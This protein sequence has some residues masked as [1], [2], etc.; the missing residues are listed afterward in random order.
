MNKNNET[1][2]AISTGSS[3]G[4][5]SIVRMSGEMST[6]I[7]DKIFKAYSGQTPSEFEPRYLNL[8]NITTENFS[9]QAMCVVFKA[10]KSYTGENLVEFQC[11]GGTQIANGIM[12]ECIKHGAR[13]ATNGEFTKRAFL[14]GK[15]S[16][17]SAEGMMDMIN[18]ESDAEIRAGY[19]LLTGN[20]SK[21]A[22]S[23]Q[24][25]LTDILSE[26]EVSF[27]YPEEIIEYIT[28]A[29]V[30]ERLENLSKQ[31]EETIETSETGKMIKSGINVLIVGRPNV[32]KSSLLNNLLQKEK[33][34]VTDIAGTTRDTVEG[35][36]LLDDIKINLIDTA[37]IHETQDTVEKIGVDKAKNLISQA[38]IVLFLVDSNREYSA[39]DE[40]IYNSIK[41]TKYIILRTKS[42]LAENNQKHF[43]DEIEISIKNN[44]GIDKLKEKILKLTKISNLSSGS[45]I[46]TNERHKN[47][48]IRSNEAI[49]RA[50]ENIELDSLDLIAIDIKQ[51]YIDIGEITGNTTSEEIIDSIF[52]K[53][54]LG[55]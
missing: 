54:C 50:I 5:I 44:Q 22:Y 34:I 11:H 48:L 52:S 36:F 25:E 37:G 38:D 19:E 27:D 26:I 41:N 40:E 3:S 6:I 2:V 39:D 33:A 45:V 29:K 13:I 10:P 47:A 55:K 15:M 30:K 49:K 31:M 21:L 7:A 42:D 24:K 17:S 8:G 46:I 1:I 4:A 18:A 20:L 9:E 28:K 32:G 14:N 12:K 51:A 23:S 35:T 43:E 16:L 53:F